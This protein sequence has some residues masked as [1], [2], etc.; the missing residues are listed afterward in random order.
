M[1]AIATLAVQLL[2]VR[3]FLSRT[4]EASP[5][6]TQQFVDFKV[7]QE[8][9][10]A[11]IPPAGSP[12]KDAVSVVN[13]LLQFLFQEHKDANP[14]LRKWVLQKIKAEC[15][16]LQHTNKVVRLVNSIKVWRVS[17][18]ENLPTLRSAALTNV[19]MSADG[20][21]FEQIEV[22]ADVEYDGGCKVVLGV[23]LPLGKSFRLSIQVKSL[24]GTVKLCFARAPYTH[25]WFSFVS[26]PRMD[27]E[28]QSH[29][30]GRSIPQI[31]ALFVNQIKKAVR[32][33]HT[34]PN[35]K[36]RVKPFF[37]RLGTRPL[38]P[39]DLPEELRRPLP[40]VAVV[41]SISASRLPAHTASAFRS[42]YCA[43]S[44]GKTPYTANT[45]RSRHSLTLLGDG[46]HA[47]CGLRL[48]RNAST[49]E[50]DGR[51][52][53]I[54]NRIVR[55]SPAHKA[56]ILKNDII[57][58]INGVTPTSCEHAEKLL[59]GS[60][61]F[62]LTVERDAPSV[63]V[64]GPGALKQD[65]MVAGGPGG[66]DRPPDRDRSSLD[67]ES[68]LTLVERQ[69]SALGD[70]YVVL[71]YSASAASS[72]PTA[73]AAA[74]DPSC[75]GEGKPTAVGA[76]GGT[77]AEGSAD[78]PPQPPPQDS[79]G[80]SPGVPRKRLAV[81][82]SGVGD[83]APASGAAAAVGASAAA[84]S[85]SG[86]SDAVW[87]AC[88]LRTAV[89]SAAGGQSCVSW[90]ERLP[91]TVEDELLHL[92]V[93]LVGVAAPG[94]EKLI[95]YVN[96]SL[97]DVV[98]ECREAAGNEYQLMLSLASGLRDSQAPDTGAS[99][100]VPAGAR[101]LERSRAGGDV[102][103]RFQLSGSSL[104]EA[105]DDDDGAVAAVASS[106]RG[107]CADE[108]PVHD[109]GPAGPEHAFVSTLFQQATY[110]DFCNRKIWFKNALKCSACSMVCHKKCQARCRTQLGGGG[111]SR[112]HRAVV[113][114]PSSVSPRSAPSSSS[115]SQQLAELRAQLPGLA[116]KIG[117]ITRR[118]LRE[119]EVVLAKGFNRNSAGRGARESPV[120]NGS[121]A[122]T[123]SLLLPPGSSAE[124]GAPLRRTHS[125]SALE[126][127]TR[128]AMLHQSTSLLSA[129]PKSAEAPLGSG[130][131][132]SSDDESELE[133]NFIHFLKQQEAVHALRSEE[134]VVTAAKEMGKELYSGVD[135][136]ERHQ[137]LENMVAK[138]QQEIDMETQLKTEVASSLRH[139]MT[140]A[141]RRA[142]NEKLLKS[143]EK[144]EALA[145]L[146]LHY[147]SG[148]QHC[149]E[150]LNQSEPL[151]KGSVDAACK[152]DV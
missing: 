114:Q 4:A 106:A 70:D 133:F 88:S 143:D 152:K 102:T 87:K 16:E 28:V 100:A 17:L 75:G 74:A 54:V 90:R 57:L 43:L 119:P 22:A 142:I 33:K 27:L 58:S 117:R 38:P 80:G 3:R 49:V 101:G 112:V 137:K 47:L 73:A 51:T 20:R 97:L 39:S 113:E 140:D 52:A 105:G 146:L 67:L 77:A 98:L 25:W 10:D 71:A 139:A 94:S 149:M 5:S 6:K 129:T 148:L 8:L 23:S 18:G 107:D 15:E 44:L 150:Q 123:S 111:C 79:V 121:Q 13:T 91:L 64:S 136:I 122:M 120:T 83:A 7:P 21:C 30:Q 103:L 59:D 72:D 147:C 2:L 138:L 29:L 69:L 131:E 50:E 109:G 151:A 61:T 24:T 12:S 19:K 104:A 32:R 116:R 132:A 134:A 144:I 45:P 26:E 110:C 76:S 1:G 128:E 84:A 86:P 126:S 118:V 89:A 65:G 41:T 82:D 53:I 85:G 92:T 34:L 48:A 36:M 95:G 60:D 93:F 66:I 68:S 9:Q 55:G 124:A 14:A 130:D 96:V 46:Q 108:A 81:S 31:T 42:F 35:Y 115:S 62:N 99:A 56:G 37:G 78:A 40:A 63:G 11:L 127:A 135:P 125:A 141:Q 145:V